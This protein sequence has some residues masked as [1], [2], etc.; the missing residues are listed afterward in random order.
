[1]VKSDCEGGGYTNIDTA[2][3]DYMKPAIYQLGEMHCYC[4]EMHELYGLNAL[5][6][7]FADG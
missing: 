5:K 2:Y 1:M 3:L 7:I 6:L 4:K